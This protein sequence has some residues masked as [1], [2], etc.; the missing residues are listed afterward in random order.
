MSS[1]FTQTLL[2]ALDS[3]FHQV[4]NLELLIQNQ[5][6][7]ALLSRLLDTEYKANLEMCYNIIRTFAA[8]SNFLEMHPLL[9]TYKAGA[10]TMKVLTHETSRVTLRYRTNSAIFSSCWVW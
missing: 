2:R 5:S 6:L 8:F 1:Y 4:E 9:A 3:M 10:L 7:M